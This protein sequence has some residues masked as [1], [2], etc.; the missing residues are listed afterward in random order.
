MAATTGILQL[1][2]RARIARRDGARTDACEA[3]RHP[4][5]HHRRHRGRRDLR[6]SPSSASCSAG[7]TTASAPNPL[8]GLIVMILAPIAAMLI[9]MAISRAREFEAD[10][11]GAEISRR[12]ECARRC[13]GKNGALRQGPAHARGRRASGDGADDDHQPALRRQAC[14]ACSAPTP[15]PRCASP[16]C[17]RWH[18]DE[19]AGKVEGR[20]G[21]P[22]TCCNLSGQPSLAAR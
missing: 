10:R 8:V 14:R 16:A 19:P 18:A 20:L 11:G 7:A 15:P 4:D 12:P 6:R 9:Q 21:R 5:F 13:P 22:S 3:P 17:G 2:T 1:L